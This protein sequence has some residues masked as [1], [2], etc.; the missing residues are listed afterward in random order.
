ML[1]K[2][3]VTILSIK[4]IPDN[5]IIHEIE[6]QIN[7]SITRMILHNIRQQIKKDSYDWY[8]KL[9]S[10]QYE[11]LHEFK[12]RINEILWLQE[13]HYVIIKN[14]EHNPHIQQTSLAGLHKL[15]I[16]LSNYYDVAPVIGK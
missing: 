3:L 11:Y 12:E 9:G 7:K 10:N 4:R 1:I 14:N 8:M 15:N 16:T 5:E 13:K 2:S 6:K